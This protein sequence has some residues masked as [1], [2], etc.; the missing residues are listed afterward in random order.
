M[1]RG[2]GVI[3]FTVELNHYVVARAHNVV[4]RYRYVRGGSETAGA[5]AE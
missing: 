1:V 3:F 2:V 4:G 5:V